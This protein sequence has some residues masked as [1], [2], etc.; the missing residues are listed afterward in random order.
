MSKD[1]LQNRLIIAQVVE[2]IFFVKVHVQW[3]ARL[4][5]RPFGIRNHD[6]SDENVLRIVVFWQSHVLC[7]CKLKR[8][9]PRPFFVTLSRRV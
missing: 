3:M 9:G 6:M 1:K 8:S 2:H 7:D 5:R 4:V